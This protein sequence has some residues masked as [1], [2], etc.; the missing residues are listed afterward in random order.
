[1]KTP[2]LIIEDGFEYTDRAHQW[3]GEDFEF[4]RAGNGAEALALIQET[5]FGLVY[6]DMN[7]NRV[8]LDELLGPW[9]EI[10]DR[11]GGDR[12]Q[13]R[14]FL[15]T[16]QGVYILSALREA[17]CGLPV[18]ISYDFS[19]EPKRWAHLRSQYKPLHY[20]SDN[21]GPDQVHNA[22]TELMESAPTSS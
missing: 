11:F 2:V 20:L 9:S 10:F 3:L 1:M 22:L 12:D 19:A 17:G 16:H 6:L 13:A 18:L 15:E 5:A 4:T 14:G 21:A 7:F 8:P